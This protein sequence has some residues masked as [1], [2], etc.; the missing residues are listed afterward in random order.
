MNAAS[1]Y[2][3]K[4]QIAEYVVKYQPLILCLTETCITDNFTDRELD[5]EGYNTIR[6]DSTSRHTGGV[7]IFTK[8]CIKF[9]NVKVLVSDVNF[10]LLSVDIKIN[11]TS[12][13]VAAVYRS[14]NANVTHFLDRF[15]QWLDV[16]IDN[17][18]NHSIILTGDFN[19]DFSKNDYAKKRL[20]EGIENHGMK[21]FI[22]NFTRVRNDS[23]TIIDLIISNDYTINAYVEQNYIITDHSIIQVKIN[24]SRELIKYQ[25]KQIRTPI[26]FNEMTNLLI[27]KEWAYSCTNVN[28]VGQTFVANIL[29][30]LD[31]V[32]PKKI[33]KV[34]V[35]ENRWLNRNCREAIDN[36]NRAYQRFVFTN[37]EEDWNNYKYARN[38]T[39]RVINEEKTIFYERN[40]DRNKSNPKLMW[41]NLKEIVGNKKGEHIFQSLNCNGVIYNNNM[42]DV[43]NQYYVGSIESIVISIG[44]DDINIDR[45][46]DIIPVVN[47]NMTSFRAVTL[48][49][50]RTLVN[51]QIKKYSTDEIGLDVIKN[52]FHILGYPLLNLI[53][54]SL[55]KG[56]MPECYK[57][58][59]VVPIPKIPNTNLAE[60]LRP[61]NMLP[62]CEKILELAVYN[63]VINYI[64][65]NN[66]L[67]TYQ[68][69]FRG[70]H[71]CETALQLV[72]SEWKQLLD[73]TG[74]GICAIFVDL[75][76]AF[77]TID[78]KI[79]LLKLK[80]YGFDQT[81]L[82]WIES[83]ITNRY[84]ITK[85]NGKLSEPIL[86]NFG[87]PQ[88]SVLGP[89][90]FIL[91]INDLGNVLSKCKIHLF[92]D[93]TLIYYDNTNFEEMI[94]T[95]NLELKLLTEKFKS[96]KLKVNELKSKC[97]FVGNNYLYN[98]FVNLNLDIVMNDEKVELVQE[99]K[100]LGLV[101]D[102][103]LKFNKH[104]EYISKKIGKKI[105][106]FRRVSPFIS[107]STK[108]T[109]YN[110][111]ILPHFLYCSSVLY[112]SCTNFSRLQ[113]LQNKAM[114][115][116][117]KCNRFSSSKLML[118]T[119]NWLNIEQFLYFQTMIFI[120][121]MNNNILPDY[122]GQQLLPVTDVHLRNTRT[123]NTNSFYVKRTI[124]SSTMKNLFH[125]GVVQFNL[126]PQEIKISKTIQR[127][128]SQ[129]LCFIK[130]TP[131]M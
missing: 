36:R 71:S 87:V 102:R 100:Y 55:E 121:K 21:Q 1:Y 43:L 92:A 124:K 69:G 94:G 29:D 108:L 110:T 131:I 122:L 114:R 112:V 77:E 115:V 113:I 120:F 50:L 24:K 34:R 4:D 45:I 98:K 47:S 23:R 83:Y 51:N 27:E 74:V 11:K 38:N 118:S 111:L 97:M 48:E 57:N 42:A 130:N 41:K 105:G 101:I 90:L 39:V 84:Q 10:W 35:S 33:V 68:S 70:K 63:Q 44:T 65:S 82:S 129:L 80:K 54:L 85:L 119:L 40:I 104:I 30:A 25:T 67:C 2:R 61:V 127:F 52:L 95:V 26:N 14:P 58:S 66:I 6:C 76:R 5:L 73:K 103:E 62:F 88:G 13:S 109:V 37:E 7:L 86:N 99:I 18:N 9:D 46:S 17:N 16:Y 59:I 78:R 75:K 22:Q 125:K 106:F 79:L 53:N 89:L 28:V 123:A 93:D 96:N 49:E 81:V 19:I 72:T 107:T 91:Y 20:Q 117:L 31:V 60:Q 15:L 12:Y 116:I 56:V 32:A 126:L 64:N 3:N 128:K 8:K